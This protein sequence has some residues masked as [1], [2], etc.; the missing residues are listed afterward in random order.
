[1][2]IVR[3]DSMWWVLIWVLIWFDEFLLKLQLLMLKEGRVISSWKDGC[4]VEIPPVSRTPTSSVPCLV[5]CPLLKTKSMQEK[6][7]AWGRTSLD[8]QCD[9]Q[10]VGHFS[11]GRIPILHL[12]SLGRYIEVWLL[13]WDC[14]RAQQD[15]SGEVG[16]FWIQRVWNKG[17]VKQLGNGVKVC[18]SFD[19]GQVWCE[20]WINTFWSFFST[21]TV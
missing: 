5:C 19:V 18:D 1:M 14:L 3:C 7:M 17:M 10:E 8:P 4:Q 12:D 15:G 9:H 2:R 20:N 13:L 6:G 16:S 21:D 11:F